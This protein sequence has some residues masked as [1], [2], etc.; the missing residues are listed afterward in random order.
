V[1]NDNMGV[2]GQAIIHAARLLEAPILKDRVNRT[3][4]NLGLIVSDFV[5]DTA[6][7]RRSLNEPAS[8]TAIEA[9]VKES[10]LRA[11]MRLFDP[12]PGLPDCLEWRVGT[13]PRDP[14][15]KGARPRGT[16][17]VLTSPSLPELTTA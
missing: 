6:I 2:S 8:Y 3:H 7:R 17:A 4:A 15:N 10:H 14:R 9:D 13:F 5:Y 11:W 1:E 16:P 12:A